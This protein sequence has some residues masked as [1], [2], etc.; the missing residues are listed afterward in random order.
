MNSW[1]FEKMTQTDK[2]LAKL[3]KEK[4]GKYKLLKI[5]HEKEGLRTGTN[6]IQK[7]IRIYF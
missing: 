7:F 6:E 3:T 5:R 2:F 4:E 1:F